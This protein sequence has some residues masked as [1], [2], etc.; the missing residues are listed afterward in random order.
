MD[1]TC[2]Q[3][4]KRTHNL[5][6]MCHTYAAWP[7][8]Q[9]ANLGRARWSP[10]TQALRHGQDSA[11]LSQASLDSDHTGTKTRKNSQDKACAFNAFLA[12]SPKVGPVD[13]DAQADVLRSNIREARKDNFSDL[14]VLALSSTPKGLHSSA[15]TSSWRK[16][17]ATA[18]KIASVQLVDHIANWP[19]WSQSTKLANAA[20]LLVCG[21]N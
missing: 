19:A 3:P 4:V 1:V 17:A 20:K 8:D 21:A 18:A 13:H 7:Q 15:A 5:W 9:G 11:V 6:H 12:T 16:V 14:K 2:I 10:R